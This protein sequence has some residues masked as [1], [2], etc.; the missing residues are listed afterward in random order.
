[1][2]FIPGW[3]ISMITFPGVILHEFA[4]EFFCKIFGV[5]VHEVKY[6]QLG[7]K[8]AWYVN[9]EKPKTYKQIFF[10]SVWPLLVNSFVAIIISFIAGQ[11]TYE[12]QTWY[13][14]LRLAISAGMHSLPSDQDM[15]HVSLASKEA[16]KNGG[17]FWHYLAFP[18]IFLVWLA[19]KL[20]IFWFDVIWAI[21]L[22]GIGGWF[23]SFNDIIKTDQDKLS[24]Q[25]EICKTQLTQ[26]ENKV[27]NNNKE[28]AK[29]EDQM[30]QYENN[31]DD[32]NYNNLV[33]PYNDLLTSTQNE[34]SIYEK[35]LTICNNLIDKY[36][37]NL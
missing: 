8:V 31:D 3:L 5:T 27:N 11:T 14:L 33:T 37:N 15:S 23:G 30:T 20:R 16:I 35:Q 9:H 24:D 19:N 4:H 7:Q 36:N 21:I 32:S 2:F 29:I 17:S 6:F 13:I 10:I 25:I 18:F 26:Y 1:M 22:V 34:I 28:L 12:S